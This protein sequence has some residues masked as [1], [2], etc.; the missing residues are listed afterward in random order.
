MEYPPVLEDTIK[1]AVLSPLIHLAGLL[2]APYHIKSEK[3]VSISAVDEGITIEGK[4]DVLVLQEQLWLIV[5]ESK[6]PTFS[7]EAGL[8]QILSYM[9]AR[10]NPERP[11]FGMI[12]TGGSFVFIK[13]V[14]NQY[15]LSR[16]FELR[17]PGNELLTVLAILKRLAKLASTEV[18]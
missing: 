1:V 18:M 14:D 8:A 10:P 13:L 17:N 7:I 11:A 4:I 6:Q 9:L 15:S 16:V 3:T 2:L 12:T 5:I